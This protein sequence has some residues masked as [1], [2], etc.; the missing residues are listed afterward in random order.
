M[1]V[2]DWIVDEFWQERVDFAITRYLKVILCLYLIE[3][4]LWSS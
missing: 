2:E 1:V 3:S 4:E